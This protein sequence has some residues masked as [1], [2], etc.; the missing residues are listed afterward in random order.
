MPPRE[1]PAYI[2]LNSLPLKKKFP[3]FFLRC[4]PICSNVH[5]HADLKQNSH[6]Q[7]PFQLIAIEADFHSPYRKCGRKIQNQIK[8]KKKKPPLSGSLKQTISMNGK[9]LKTFGR[10]NLP[11]SFSGQSELRCHCYH[12]YHERKDSIWEDDPFSPR[13]RPSWENT[14]QAFTRGTITQ[15]SCKIRG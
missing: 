14:S 6:C 1:Y 13:D 8:T 10:H 12:S 7:L 15:R 3:I 4:I 5:V 11:S 2:Y 9:I